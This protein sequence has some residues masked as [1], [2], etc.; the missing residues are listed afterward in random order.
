MTSVAG[1]QTRGA[2]IFLGMPKRDS[3]DRDT[4]PSDEEVTARAKRR[5][6]KADKQIADIK[7][8]AA[9]AKRRAGEGKRGLSGVRSWG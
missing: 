3:R 9:R 7:E 4:V 6:A 5:F 2:L 8:D 1:A